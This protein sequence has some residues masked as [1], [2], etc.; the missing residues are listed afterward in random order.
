[1]EVYLLKLF[2]NVVELEFDITDEDGVHSFGSSS[3][4]IR[5]NLDENGGTI[6]LYRIGLVCVCW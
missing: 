3:Q 4:L 2:I 6:G 5:M 1:M